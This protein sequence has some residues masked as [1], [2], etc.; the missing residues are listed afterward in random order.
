MNLIRLWLF[1]S[2]SSFPAVLVNAS[3]VIIDNLLKFASENDCEQKSTFTSD[4]KNQLLTYLNKMSQSGLATLLPEEPPLTY[5]RTSY[6]LYLKKISVC[7]QFTVI[8]MTNTSILESKNYNL[9]TD[10]SNYAE[11]VY[12]AITSSLFN[13]SLPKVQRLSGTKDM[14]MI[15]VTEKDGKSI[16]DNFRLDIIGTKL[17]SSKCKVASGICKCSDLSIFDFKNQIKNL[18]EN[19]QLSKIADISALANWQFYSDFSFYV[20]IGVTV[21]SV[22]SILLIEFRLAKTNIL[23]PTYHKHSNML[24][25]IGLGFLVSF[26][27]NLKK[28]RSTI[29]YLMDCL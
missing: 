4:L 8:N 23:S 10:C 25:K 16:I 26:K 20:I 12:M 14:I 21:I 29:L 1:F 18:F 28:N 9:S 22:G 7:T 2:N 13:C 3:T 17:C 27:T 6:D 11:I 24:K 19:S 15:K 5:N